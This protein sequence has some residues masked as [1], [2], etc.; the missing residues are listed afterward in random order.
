ML[1]TAAAFTFWGLLGKESSAR[2]S[3]T[4]IISGANSRLPMRGMLRAML[5]ADLPLAQTVE[6]IDSLFQLRHSLAPSPTADALSCTMLE[7]AVDALIE[8]YR[9]TRHIAPGPEPLDDAATALVMHWTTVAQQVFA[10]SERLIKH[11]PEGFTVPAQMAAAIVHCMLLLPMPSL[12]AI[13]R[14]MRDFIPWEK[15]LAQCIVMAW[16]PPMPRK[17]QFSFVFG[18]SPEDDLFTVLCEWLCCVL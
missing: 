4:L 12:T 14:V 3:N 7:M 13:F 10:N 5:R 9:R 6:N 2:T 17:H 16:Q 1:K 15:A 8:A 11:F 18:I